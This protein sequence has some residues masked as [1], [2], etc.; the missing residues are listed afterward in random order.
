MVS[1]SGKEFHIV[2]PDLETRQER[3]VEQP[4]PFTLVAGPGSCIMSPPVRM[5]FLQLEGQE[6]ALVGTCCGAKEADEEGL[7][8]TSLDDPCKD[9]QLGIVGLCELHHGTEANTSF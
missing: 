6:I 1:F 2:F 3:K 4:L 9:T 5:S 8:Q 7:P